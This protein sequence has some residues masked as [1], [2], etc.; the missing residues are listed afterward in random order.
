MLSKA[1]HLILVSCFIFL[2]PVAAQDDVIT[3]GISSFAEHSVNEPLIGPTVNAIEKAL[4]PIAVRVENLKLDELQEALKAKKLDLVISSAGN[5]RRFLIEG[6]GLRDLATIVS[7]QAPNPNFAEGSVFFTCKDRDDINSISEL[8]GKSLGANY[9]FAFSGWQIAEGELHKRNIKPEIFFS[10][11]EFLGHGA[12][13]VLDAVLSGKLDAGVI[14]S[15]ILENSG[16]LKRGKVKILDPKNPK[17]FPCQVSTDLY[18]NWTLST[19]PNTPPEISRKVTAA[20]LSMKPQ[21]DGLHWSVATDFTPIDNLFRE[22]E[23][24]PFEYLRH[25][26]IKR[27]FETYWQYFLFGLILLS[28]LIYH[29]LRSDYLVKKRTKALSESLHRERKLR[30]QGATVKRRLDKLQKIG[31]VGQM[32]SMIAHELKQ[33]LGAA[34]AY[35]FALRRRMENGEASQDLVEKTVERVDAQIQR[36]SQVVEQVRSYAKGQK[37]RQK[38][39]FCEVANKT[40]Q[41]LKT[42]LPDQN[43]TFFNSEKKIFVESNPI[44]LQIILINLVKNAAEAISGK[45]DGKVTVSLDSYENLARLSISDNGNVLSDSEWNQINEFTASTAKA[46]GLGFGLSIVS[47]LVSD[48]GGRIRFERIKLGGLKVIVELPEVKNPREANASSVRNESST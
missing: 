8:K 2:A 30:S 18:P 12:N 1:Q 22:L 28:V 43:L 16:L 5:Y 25:F 23:I 14:R 13:P 27:F 20:V 42:S 48:M 26:S 41:D 21:I 9:P 44:E 47:S 24:G 40:I 29:S 31:L 19:T 36:A 35:C 46:G 38:V 6:Y 45:I 34:S 32:C 3:I 17:D 15:C 7:N 39:D 10:K 11:V 33:P 37:K 4:F